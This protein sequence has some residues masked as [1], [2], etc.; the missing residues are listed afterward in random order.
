MNKVILQYWE[1]SKRGW[2]VRP[3]GCSL[4]LTLDYHK[5]F[6]DS[7]YKDRSLDNVPDEY[8]RVVGDYIEVDIDDL[9]Y[10]QLV[11]VGSVRISQPSL[12]NLLKLK[13]INLK[14]QN[15]VVVL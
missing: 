13:V 4:H 6:V 2:V 8:E 1:E 14:I 15:D 12:N 10:N 11:V 7:V 5:S 3:D 9:L